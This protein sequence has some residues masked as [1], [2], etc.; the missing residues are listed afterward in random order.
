MHL[1]VASGSN[2]G[3]VTILIYFL[4]SLFIVSR[5][6]KSFLALFFALIYTLIAGADA[7][8]IRAYLM[9]LTSTIGFLLGRKSGL[10]QGL[11]L[12]GFLILLFNPQSLFEAGFEMSFLAT[13]AI[14]LFSTNF[15]LKYRLN[16]ITKNN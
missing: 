9:T 2:V 4:C 10:L 11:I 5:Y 16:K 14:V 1:L 15:S 12:A 13:L 6:K 7:P 8:L 3:F